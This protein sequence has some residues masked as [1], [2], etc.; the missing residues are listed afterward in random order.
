MIL[1]LIGTILL[2]SVISVGLAWPIAA[3]LG[4]AAPEKFLATL[5]LSLLA[6]YLVAWAIYVWSLP[7]LTVWVLPFAAIASLFFGRRGLADTWRDRDVRELIVAQ[8]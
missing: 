1:D 4:C 5:S 6:V 3:R 8:A 2:Y 7:I